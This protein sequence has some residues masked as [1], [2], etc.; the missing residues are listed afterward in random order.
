M[1]REQARFILRSFRP[2]G[3]DSG[4][5]DFEEALS[6]ATVDGEL[7]AWLEVGWWERLLA[8]PEVPP[9]PLIPFR[10]LEEALS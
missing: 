6:V 1:D 10:D 7:G 5:P 9:R 3:A 8:A 4:N 2:D